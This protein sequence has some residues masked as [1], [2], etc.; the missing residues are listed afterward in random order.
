MLAPVP[1]RFD[2]GREEAELSAYLGASFDR[3]RLE[4]Y[5]EALDEEAKAV[6]D[7]HELY[8]TSQAYLYNLTVFAMTGTKLPYLDVLTSHLP[9]GSRLLDYGCGIGSDG[10]MLLE[11]GYRVEFA[12]FANPSTAYLRWRLEHRGLS[13]PVHDLDG[14]VPGG[15]DGTYAFDVIE[16]VK[17]PYGFLGEMERRARFVEVNF[18]EFDPNEQELHYELPIEDLLRYVERRHLEAYELLHGTS[19]LVL[20]N[21]APAGTLRRARNRALVAA[22]RLRRRLGQRT[23]RAT[24]TA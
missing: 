2:P 17:D 4:H 1:L 5:Q 23:G 3:G 16:H 20:Y 22:T 24:N 8:R 21:P 10:L 19:H 12:D 13:A 18:L 7:E 14:E 6:R 9:K 11:A 15:F